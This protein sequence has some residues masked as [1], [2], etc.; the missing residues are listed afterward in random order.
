MN[1]H[2]HNGI[3]KRIK[4]LSEADDTC[5]GLGD[6]IVEYCR[7]CVLEGGLWDLAEVWFANDEESA[8]KAL[9]NFDTFDFI[10]HIWGYTAFTSV[11]CDDGSGVVI[12]I[13]ADIAAKVRPTSCAVLN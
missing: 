4:S 1:T 3:S 9:A 12:F 7:Q 13:P 6:A 5:K 11:T 2:S 8:T 10:D